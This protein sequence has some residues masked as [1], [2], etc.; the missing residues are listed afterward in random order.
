M[1]KTAAKRTLAAALSLAVVLSFS[2]GL[3]ALASGEV[4]GL[5]VSAVVP[6]YAPLS[7]QS[8]DIEVQV[9]SNAYSESGTIDNLKVSF[10]LPTNVELLS[11]STSDKFTV[12][13]SNLPNV[14]VRWNSDVPI[15]Q[16]QRVRFNLRF[17]QGVSVTGTTTFPATTITASAT[18]ADNGSVVTPIVNVTNNAVNSPMAVTQPTGNGALLHTVHV[19]LTPEDIIGGLNQNNPTVQIKVPYGLADGYS[20]EITS[21]MLGGVNYSGSYSSIEYDTDPVYGP[22]SYGVYTIPTNAINDLL[23]GETKRDITI[24]YKYPQPDTNVDNYYGGAPHAPGVS[25]VVVNDFPPIKVVYSATRENGAPIESSQDIYDHASLIIPLTGPPATQFAY[26]TA[27]ESNPRVPGFTQGYKIT[28]MPLL[29]MQDIVIIDNPVLNEPDFF[30]ANRFTEISWQG[31]TELIGGSGKVKTRVWYELYSDPGIWV[32]YTASPTGE[33]AGAFSVSSLG[34][35]ANDYITQLKFGFYT[36]G[37][38]ATIPAGAGWVIIDIDAELAAGIGDSGKSYSPA[39]NGIGLLTNTITVTGTASGTA[40]QD[41]T[42]I[43]TSDTELL[44]AA[45][46]GI[47]SYSSYISDKLWPSYAVGA[48]PLTTDWAG[49]SATWYEFFS[50]EVDPHVPGARVVNTPLHVGD[51]V[52]VGDMFSVYNQNLADASMLFSIPAGFEV[53]EI[54][55]TTLRIFGASYD[56]FAMPDGTTVVNVKITSPNPFVGT[57]AEWGNYGLWGGDTNTTHSR[58]IRVRLRVLPGAVS[59]SIYMVIGTDNLAQEFGNGALMSALGNKNLFLDSGLVNATGDNYHVLAGRG[60]GLSVDN[61]LGLSPVSSASATLAGTYATRAAVSAPTSPATGFYG[62]HIE[63]SSEAGYGDFDKVRVIDMLPQIGDTMT[64]SSVPRGS[65]LVPVVQALTDANGA[66]TTGLTLY[67]SENATW[68]TARLLLNDTAV[69]PAGP[70]WVAWDGSSPLPTTAKAILIDKNT[71][72]G[73]SESLD[74]R[75][76]VEVPAGASTQTAWNS[77]ATGGMYTEASATKHLVPGEPT[78]AALVRGATYTLSGS[79]WNDTNKNG[80]KDSGESYWSDSLGPIT[81]DIY[82]T[83]DLHLGSAQTSNGAYS[84]SALT[85]GSYYV[86]FNLPANYQLSPTGTGKTNQF[87]GAA[88]RAYRNV[89]NYNIIDVDAGIYS[90]LTWALTYDA[91]I[92]TGASSTGVSTPAPQPGISDGSASAAVGVPTGTPKKSDGVYVFLGWNTVADGTGADWYYTGTDTVPAQPSGTEYKLYAQWVF[93]PYEKHFFYISGYP[94]GTVQPDGK[95]TRAEAAQVFYRLSIERGK[96]TVGDVVYTNNYSDVPAG[97]WYTTAVSSV[98]AW[99]YLTG[100]PVSGSAFEPGKAITRA[101]LAV[102]ASNFANTPPTEPDADVAPVAFT[103]IAGHWAE[104]YIINAAKKGYFVGYGD[105][106]FRPDENITRAEFMQVVN[107]AFAR[108]V[109][110]D[111]DMLP[112]MKTWPDNADKTV[113]YYAAVQEATNS[114]MLYRTEQKVNNLPFYYE[115]W[116]AIINYPFVVPGTL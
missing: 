101:E 41:P 71:G 58:Q 15:G 33:L 12:D 25:P 9:T 32:E 61:T 88:P 110:G 90:T 81:V 19:Y 6:T 73:S 57:S 72:L 24:N 50:S 7:G 55:Y 42:N 38:S 79:V 2:Q 39:A 67:Y 22:V 34:L 43:A 36:E 109:A 53:L 62:L 16:L 75:I 76:K 26:K 21:I 8:F 107:N 85:A 74:L 40:F 52:W 69:A 98:K 5:S 83:E 47:W 102:I 44:P 84:F 103:D 100:L 113:W 30:A 49:Q 92:P 89:S 78:K 4:A 91:N 114:H 82:D 96:F 66:P 23:V 60:I 18:N 20:A 46:K 97:D 93:E 112:N 65:D 27:T 105:Q 45:V 1:L 29:E 31:N 95:L 108:R 70:D 87:S 59:G 116:V 99:S 68:S 80:V 48:L 3:T 111:A 11:A 86:T 56:T 54:G 17:K 115:K 28:F 37:G 51:E 64:I 35:A 10:T 13:T 94:D 63:N 106:T 77:F 14:V 104:T